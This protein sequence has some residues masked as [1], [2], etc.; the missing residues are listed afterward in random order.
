MYQMTQSADGTWQIIDVK[1]GELATLGGLRLERLDLAE[2]HSALQM[3][4]S[5]FILSSRKDSNEPS[6]RP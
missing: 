4:Q 5:P 3:L 2:A 1:T 6:E